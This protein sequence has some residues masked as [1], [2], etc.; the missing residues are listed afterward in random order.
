MK[1]I[2]LILFGAALAAGCDQVN[3]DTGDASSSSPAAPL[4][5]DTAAA[6]TPEDKIIV[7][8]NGVEIPES[9]L[10]LYAGGAPITDGNREEVIRNIVTG[11]LITQAAKEAGFGDDPAVRSELILAEQSVFG[12]AYVTQFFQNHPISD[13]QVAARYE[14]LKQELSGEKEYNVAHILVE[15]EKVAQ[16]LLQQIQAD[17]QV[18]EKLAG[19]H[20][21]DPGSGA[22]GG[23]LG[24]MQPQALVPEFAEAMKTLDS[25]ELSPTPVKTQFGWH[26]IRVD[27]T[28]DASP[29]EL[30]DE[31]RERIRQGEQSQLLN[32]HIE[33]LRAKA[34][35][36][37]R[38]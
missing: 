5:S 17:G 19:E 30:S 10:A 8:V 2:V 34:N 28:R 9:R 16:D 24:W 31:L 22:N 26:I 32:R 38:E 1:K 20:S 18:F 36:E 27:E 35:I 13:E 33:E 21:I 7:V 3:N 6:D 25:G 4:I 14:T 37:I 29:P 23:K 11:E 15:D 12:R